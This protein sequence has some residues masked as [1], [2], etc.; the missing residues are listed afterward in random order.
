MKINIGKSKGVTFTKGE[1][2]TSTVWSHL[3][4]G[5]AEVV[6]NHNPSKNNLFYVRN[7]RRR[8]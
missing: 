2:V 7:S 4:M 3:P 6:R 5:N 1:L 8:R